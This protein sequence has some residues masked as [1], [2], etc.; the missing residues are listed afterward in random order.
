ML[1]CDVDHVE[2]TRIIY[3]NFKKQ[4]TTEDSM[5]PGLKLCFMTLSHPMTNKSLSRKLFD[6]ETNV[7]Y[8]YKK[9]STQHFL[10][11][12]QKKN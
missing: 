11:E 10:R 8:C 4:A 7:V 1:W 3:L 5:R 9:L 12:F 6:A 2:I